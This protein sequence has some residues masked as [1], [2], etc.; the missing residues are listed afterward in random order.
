MTTAHATPLAMHAVPLAVHAV[1]LHKCE[2][3][4]R[5]RR[6]RGACDPGAETDARSHMG[7]TARPAAFSASPCAK[8]SAS[9]RPA[10]STDDTVA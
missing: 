7:E 5:V 8:N 4:Q 9:T 6:G 3:W 2:S 10:H 1:P